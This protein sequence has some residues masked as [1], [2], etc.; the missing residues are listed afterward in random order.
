MNCLLSDLLTLSEPLIR[1]LWTILS[2]FNFTSSW[3]E[4][5]LALIRSLWRL[6]IHCINS[7]FV[8]SSP[9][10]R[11]IDFR[12]RFVLG[13]ASNTYQRLKISVVWMLFFN[14]KS[15]FI[16][17]AIPTK[18]QSHLSLHIINVFTQHIKLGFLMKYNILNL[19]VQIVNLQRI[20]W[21]KFFFIKCCH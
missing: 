4:W 19:C 20:F 12:L 18:Y 13:N 9:P 1:F 7:A 16:E 5:Y 2:L 15:V 14:P 10:L 21:I 8:T 11:L 17:F 6:P 3:S